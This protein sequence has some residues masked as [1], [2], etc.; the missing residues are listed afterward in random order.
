M[1]MAVVPSSSSSFEQRQEEMTL[2]HEISDEFREVAIADLLARAMTITVHHVAENLPKCFFQEETI[3]THSVEKSCS[4]FVAA[5]Q[6][7]EA[8]KPGGDAVCCGD[9]STPPLPEDSGSLSPRSLRR[10]LLDNAD[11]VVHETS[12]SH[13]TFLSLPDFEEFDDYRYNLENVPCMITCSFEQTEN[14]DDDD[15]TCSTIYCTG[16]QEN[17]EDDDDPEVNVR[18]ML[19][20]QSSAGFISMI[21]DLDDDS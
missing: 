3:D 11:C 1:I 15:V 5:Q 2:V 14:G 10:E 17:E 9:R 19:Q 12:P 20:R 13:Q 4:S 7:D 8:N 21:E 16:E 18:D 6:E